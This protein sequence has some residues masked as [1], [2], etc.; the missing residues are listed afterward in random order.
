MR[1]ALGTLQLDAF[2]FLPKPIQW[3]ALEDV[4]GRLRQKRQKSKA[5]GGR[6]ARC[7]PSSPSPI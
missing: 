7:P 5:G 2:D 1:A 3:Q 6:I 4:I